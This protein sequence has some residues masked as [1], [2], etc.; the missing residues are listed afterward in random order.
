MPAH[1]RW[2]LN[3]R[4]SYKREISNSAAYP[5]DIPV[6]SIERQL[7]LIFDRRRRNGC[8]GPQQPISTM[9]SFEVDLI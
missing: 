8:A 7:L 6:A 9:L 2:E 4:Q 3:H 5:P 1:L